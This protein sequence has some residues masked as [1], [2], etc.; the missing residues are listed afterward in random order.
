MFFSFPTSFFFLLLF[1]VVIIDVIDTSAVGVDVSADPVTDAV[2]PVISVVCVT[3]SAAFGIAASSSVVAV[4]VFF[5]GADGSVA[6][7]GFGASGSSFSL[8]V[9]IAI[10]LASAFASPAIRL[11]RIFFPTSVARGSSGYKREKIHEPA[12][13][14][15]DPVF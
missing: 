8:V 4:A 9:I 10:I 7:T 3:V 13:N 14:F 15:K 2:T 6:G 11:S 1:R 12:V 5:S